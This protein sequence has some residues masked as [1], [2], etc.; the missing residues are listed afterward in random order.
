M[1]TNQPA[2]RQ[3]TVRC[4]AVWLLAMIAL[5]APLLATAL[6]VTDSSREAVTLSLELPA[7]A[8]R[9][10]VSNVAG[11]AAW[12]A[13][14]P[15]FVATATPGQVRLPRRGWS[16]VVPPGTRPR[17]EVVR[18]T[19]RD[20]DGRRL[21]FE[22]VPVMERDPETGDVVE[23]PLVLTDQ[24]ELPRDRVPAT[25]LA[26]LRNPDVVPPTGPAV[27]LGEPS[28][29]RG[30]R[31]VTVQVIP[32]RDDGDGRAARALASGAWRVRFVPDDRAAKALPT[33]TLRRHS[34]KGDA[35]FAR[36]FLNGDLL[37]ALPTEA[38]A[39][40]LLGGAK[41]R[42]AASGTPL[43]YP[44]VRLPVARTQLYRVRASELVAAGLMPG[45]GAV[46]VSQLRLYQRRYAAELD[47]PASDIARPYVEVEVPIHVVG[48]G[49]SSM[50][51]TCSCSGGCGRPTT[52]PS[53]WS[54]MAWC[55]ISA[56]PAMRTSC[57]TS[58]T[59]TGCSTP[60]PTR[61]SRG[62]AWR[63]SRCR[64]PAARPSR[65]TAAPT[66]SRRPWPTG[67]ACR[68]STSTATTSTATARRA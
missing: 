30:R 53:P 48:D 56:T 58:P 47:D 12:D 4:G 7:P 46:D 64:R 24:T 22:L 42:A 60:T 45:G 62:R 61:A 18:E 34:S 41:A 5:A 21:A 25:V 28:W 32:V 38:A 10:G 17:L 13:V 50:V 31:V 67:R 59:P 66:A 68:A 23:R 33:G 39:R 6:E 57:S 15:G 19:W 20:L 27:R 65:R 40:G 36:H 55:T 16:L 35:R 8:W 54:R 9:P 37:A 44:D 11:E 51:T 63:T 52:A 2:G 43:G 26:D 3:D 29:W 14:L 49:A 1:T